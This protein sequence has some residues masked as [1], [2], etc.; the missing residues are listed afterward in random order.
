MLGI[1]LLRITNTGGSAV[2]GIAPNTTAVFMEGQVAGIILNQSEFRAPTATGNSGSVAGP[3]AK[4]SS[5]YVNTTGTFSQVNA[6]ATLL[7]ELG[8]LDNDG[9]F[10]AH[11]SSI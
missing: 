3:K 1:Q 4:I 9:Y 6:G 10:N 2:A 5:A 11:L 8:I 7:I